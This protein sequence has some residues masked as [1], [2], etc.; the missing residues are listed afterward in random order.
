[1]TVGTAAKNMSVVKEEQ[2]QAGNGVQQILFQLNHR[3]E[4]AAFFSQRSE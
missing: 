2:S 4:T 3:P 1:M